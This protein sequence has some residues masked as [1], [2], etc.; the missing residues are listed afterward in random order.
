MSQARGFTLI[1]LLIVVAII[2]LIA[3]IAVPNLMG[4]MDKGRQTRTMA[5]MKQ[6]AAAITRYEID[7]NRFPM[8]ASGPVGGGLNALLEPIYIQKCPTKDGWG[9]ALQWISDGQ[10]EVYSLASWG[11]GGQQGPENGGDTN[12]FTDDIVLSNGQFTQKPEGQQK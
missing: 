7:F 12:N 6:I 3:V 8:V 4:A 11:K 10:G 1:E 9:T 5:D 2:G